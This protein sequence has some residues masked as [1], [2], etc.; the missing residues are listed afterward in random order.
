M[1]YLKY[2]PANDQEWLSWV[3]KCYGATQ[4]LFDNYQSGKEIKIHTLYSEQKDKFHGKP[5]YGKCAY[6]ETN[7]PVSSPDYVEHFRPKRGVRNIDN[8]IIMIENC[9][10]EEVAHP[11]YIWLAY[12]WT[13]LLPTCWKCNTWH[14]D[15]QSGQNIGKG[16][17]FP[18]TNGYA[19]YPGD[20]VN[21]NELLINPMVD[22]PSEHIEIDDLGIIHNKE[23][24]L[25]GQTVIDLFGLNIRDELIIARKAE[26]DNIK[27]R[28]KLH[29][30]MDETE[31]NYTKEH[32]EIK[33]IQDGSKPYTLA[34]RKAINDEY[35]RISNILSKLKN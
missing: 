6:C 15:R 8:E 14:I 1:I 33:N 26:Y 17:R 27:R 35:E 13:N 18:V 25:R 7:I 10:G 30:L 34:A 28:I 16:N 4:Q 3:Q 31:S 9:S 12:D 19:I 24:S 11:G 32:E 29:I 20:E 23:D 21:E 5:F 2:N 22:D